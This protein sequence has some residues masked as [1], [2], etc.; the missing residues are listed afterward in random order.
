[1]SFISTVCIVFMASVLFMILYGIAHID[2][3][4]AHG[5][6][7]ATPPLIPALRRT[8][9]NPDGTIQARTKAY[10]DDNDVAK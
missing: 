9:V 3:G 10:D 7:V 2:H 8:R 4:L 1:M 5:D 6:E